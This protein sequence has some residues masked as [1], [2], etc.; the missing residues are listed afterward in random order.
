MTSPT[1]YLIRHGQTE[2]SLSGQH[3][4]TTDIPLTATG[5]AEARR[6]APWLARV[7][8][9]HVFASPRQRARRTA[10]LSGVSESPV[11]EPD[12]AEWHYGDYEG[13]TSKQIKQ[14]RPG[15]NIFADGCPGG[16]SP[17]EMTARIDRLIGKLASL[18]GNIALFTH[19]HCG[20]VLGA[21]WAGL[22]ISEAEHLL[23]GTATLNILGYNPSH[24]EVRVIALWN[25]S[26][27]ILGA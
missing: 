10:A 25:A 14:T 23:L 21:R 18:A 19:G 17:A 16:E 8:F 24:P 22:P 5:E 11:I 3:T 4:G 12:L 26:P 7:D 9:A 1:L 13:I 2:W 15:W 6:L 20:V 27:A